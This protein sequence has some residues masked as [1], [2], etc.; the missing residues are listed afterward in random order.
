MMKINVIFRIC[1]L[2][3]ELS[4]VSGIKYELSKLSL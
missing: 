4:F 3:L 1:L 2:S